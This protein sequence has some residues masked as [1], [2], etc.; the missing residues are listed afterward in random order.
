MNHAPVRKLTRGRLAG[1]VILAIGA[2]CVLAFPGRSSAARSDVDIVAIRQAIAEQHAGFTVEENWIT[3]LSPAERA[4]LAGA[5][6]LEGVLPPPLRRAAALVPPALDWRDYNGHSYVSG[7]RNQG[8]CGSCWIFG[9]VAMLESALMIAE[10]VPDTDP[11]YSEQ[12]VLSCLSNGTGCNGGS[13]GNALQF[14]VT[15]GSPTESCSPYQADDDVPCPAACPGYG[16]LVVRLASWQAVC[17]GTPDPAA[18]KNALQFGPVGAMMDLYDDFYAYSGG[19]YSHVSGIRW[20]SHYVLIVGYDDARQCWIV[21]NDFDV[22]WGEE[23]FC[24]IAY[25]ANCTFGAWAMTC[26]FA[27]RPEVLAALQRPATLAVATGTTTAPVYGRVGIAG[28]TD[29]PGAAPG[30]RMQLGYGPDGSDPQL[31]PGAWQ[32]ADATYAGDEGSEDEYAATLDIAVS[33]QYD[34]CY[35]CSYSAGSWVYG[36]LD[37]STNGYAPAQAGALTAAAVTFTPVAAGLAGAEAGAVCWGDCDGDGRL[38]LLVTGLTATSSLSRVYRN[39]GDGSFTDIAAGLTGASLGSAAWGDY[40]NDGDLDILQTGASPTYVPATIVYRNNGGGSFTDAGAGLPAIY[41]SAVAWGDGDD[42]G[43]LDILLAGTT[44]TRIA[45]V[46]RNNGNGTFTDSNAGLVGVS[47]GAAVWGD[48]DADGDLD[49]LLAGNTPTGQI[50]RIYGNDGG[51]F[52]DIN[53]GL[54][55]VTLGAAAWC[56]GD[57]DGDLDP[58]LTGLTA[59][60]RIS[61]IYRNDGGVFTDVGAGLPGIATGAVAWGDCDQDGRPDLLLAGHTGSVSIARVYRSNRNGTFTD[62]NLGLTGVT[63]PSAAWGDYDGDGDLDLVIAGFN[64]TTEITQLYRNNCVV[65]NA[66]PSAPTGLLAQVNGDRVTFSWNAAADD[67]TPTGSLSYNLRIGTTAGGAQ[68]MPGMANA[69]SGVRRLPRIG[70]AQQR[71]QWTV[72]LPATPGPFYWS[73][74]A[75][76][77]AFAGGP[78]AAERV[79]TPGL[80]GVGDSPASPRLLSVRVVPNPFNPLTTIRFDLPA[81]GKVRLAVYD[82]AGRLVRVLVE[83]EV[84]AGSHEAVWDGRDG[85][86]RSASS[87]SYLARLVAGGRVEVARMELVR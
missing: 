27:R 81:A 58:V 3:Q 85:S 26:T 71:L 9:S 75:I 38:D 66:A 39:N 84:S 30:M 68:I 87:G 5:R 48:Y 59:T 32:W 76:D 10:Q 74:Q 22:W 43:D 6:P 17:Y 70:N 67:R 14:L 35:R 79:F 16:D 21:K 18:I 55:G 24:Q 73:V 29:G 50:A 33:G 57:G 19:V 13:P 65:P 34:Y 23:G 45:R 64:G 8:I 60:A 7:V 52:T 11:D 62:L 78:F 1:L 31:N 49:I 51:A 25:N 72:R 40:D 44:G 36:D 63:S 28:I 82:V 69:A 15:T 37:G 41:S 46:Y 4:K 20:G 42:D 2:A 56:D 77:G 80:V 83:G 47:S 61:N 86:G 53:A 54:P 12:F